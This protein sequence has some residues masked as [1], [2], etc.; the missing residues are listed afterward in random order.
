[1]CL[2]IP[3]RVITVEGA[4]LFRTGRISFGGMIREVN[5]SAVPEAWPGSYVLVHA[6]M[7][8]SVIDE[9]EASRVFEYLDQIDQ[10]G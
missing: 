8:I 7:A 9:A 4:D 1:M 10:L 3:G 2:A 5:L 6:G